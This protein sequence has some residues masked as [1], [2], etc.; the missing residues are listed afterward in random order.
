MTTIE[1]EK[2]ENRRVHSS[3]RCQN[4]YHVS[5][6]AGNDNDIISVQSKTLSRQ[7]ITAHSCIILVETSHVL[8]S[9]Y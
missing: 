8:Y 5:P 3:P 4:T 7:N 2:D 9:N 1:K 6:A